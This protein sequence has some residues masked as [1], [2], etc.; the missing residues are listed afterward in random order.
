MKL[1][2][3]CH[4]GEIMATSMKRCGAVGLVS[5]GGLRDVKEVEALG[6]LHYF[7]RGLVVSHGRP[8][9]YGEL[10]RARGTKNEPGL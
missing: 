7:G 1:D 5:D 3:S 9:I 6:G 10:F 8:I 2:L 4:A